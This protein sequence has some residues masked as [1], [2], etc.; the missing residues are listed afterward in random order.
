MVGAV[1]CRIRLS[2]K[3]SQPSGSHYCIPGYTLEVPNTSR[4]RRTISLS[5]FLF[6]AASS[7]SDMLSL[8]SGYVVV[9]KSQ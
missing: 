6:A 4:K 8:N 3:F 2:G 5:H 1:P 9:M 7:N